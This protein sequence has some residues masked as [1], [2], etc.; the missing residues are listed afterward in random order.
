M[1]YLEIGIRSFLATVFAW[2]AISKIW[3][4]DSRKQFHEYLIYLFHVSMRW[5]TRL[6]ALLMLVE[7]CIPLLLAF[8]V[9]AGPGFLVSLAMTAV[10]LVTVLLAIRA[11]KTRPCRC[12]G[13]TSV[14]LGVRHVLRNAA[15]FLLAVLGLTLT[16][17][18]PLPLD[19]LSALTSVSCGLAVALMFVVGEKLGTYCMTPVLSTKIMHQRPLT[20]ERNYSTW[21]RSRLWPWACFRWATSSSS[22]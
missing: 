8:D 14:P 15:F 11:K 6:A 3:T 2:A 4:R 7:F 17:Q 21:Q 20:S 12:F 16:T 9:T 18:E 5:A 13:D 19:A 22:C 1:V 10:L